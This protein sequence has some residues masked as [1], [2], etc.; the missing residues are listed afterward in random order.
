MEA[1]SSLT[2]PFFSLYEPI[3]FYPQRGAVPYDVPSY[4]NSSALSPVSVVN[5]PS[6]DLSPVPI[7]FP[8][9]Q[10]TKHGPTTAPQQESA[11]IVVSSDEASMSNKYKGVLVEIDSPLV[12]KT[13][14]EEWMEMYERL[15]AYRKVH[16]TTQVPKRYEHDRELARWVQHQRKYCENLDQIGLLNGIG[17]VWSGSE[18]WMEMYERLVEYQKEHKTTH[19][20]QRSRHDLK[21]AR[22]ICTQRYNCKDPERIDL[23]NK[24][25]FI[26]K[27]KRNVHYKRRKYTR[28]RKQG[29]NANGD[30]QKASS[31]SKQMK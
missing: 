24:I 2:H 21:L 6:I 17:F 16:K 23:L 31:K 3:S 11:T 28:S 15:V 5:T 13:P 20:P 12:H 8:S 9:V 14:D 22:W 29:S 7:L 10:P 30:G 19:I 25:G 18:S 27:P 26:W 1:E 4:I